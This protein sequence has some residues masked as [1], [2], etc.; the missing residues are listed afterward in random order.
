MLYLSHR[1]YESEFLLCCCMYAIIQL[2]VVVRPHLKRSSVS[3]RCKFNAYN[4]PLNKCSVL[5]STLLL[6][7][8]EKT[9]HRDRDN[10]KTSR[11]A[12]LI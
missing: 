12:A 3:M 6:E 5:T 1:K 4:G 9:S 2:L 8:N 10:W 7:E 11:T